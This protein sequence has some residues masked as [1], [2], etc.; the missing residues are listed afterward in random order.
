MID[1]VYELMEYINLPDSDDTFS[2]RKNMLFTSSKT[3]LSFI[4]KDDFYGICLVYD[5]D[6]YE[7]FNMSQD[8]YCDMPDP[9]YDF[10][11]DA[12]TKIGD[13]DGSSLF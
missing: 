11:V 8:D 9:L 13:F 4:E 1:K 2:E 3:C 7:D 6:E 5:K 12:N 10:T